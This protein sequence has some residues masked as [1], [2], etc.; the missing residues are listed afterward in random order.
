M[1]QGPSKEDLEEYSTQPQACMAKEILAVRGRRH[2]LHIYSVYIRSIQYHH[3]IT[4]NCCL[5]C[6]ET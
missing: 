2:V 3:F 4:V 5:R 1:V 6:I